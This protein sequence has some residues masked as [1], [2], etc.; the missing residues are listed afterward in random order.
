MSSIAESESMYLDERGPFPLVRPASA[1]ELCELVRGVAATDEAIFPKGGGTMLDY[2]LPPNKSG[3]VCDL[4]RL[5][6]VVDYPADDMTVT[7]EAGMTLAELQRVLGQ[8]RQWLP[9]DAPLPERTTIGGALATN[10]P[11]PRR[12][13]YGTWRDY[14]LGM[15]VVNDQGELTRSGGR[16][17]KNVAGYDLHKLHIGALGTLGVIVEV[18]FKVRPLP[19]SRALL[20]WRCTEDALLRIL[21][22]VQATQTRPV[23]ITVLNDRAAQFA[24]ALRSWAQPG[25]Y[26]V[27]IGFEGKRSTVAWQLTQLRQELSQVEQCESLGEWGDEASQDIWQWLADF[28]LLASAKVSFRASV[29]PSQTPYLLKATKH[30]GQLAVIAHAGSG[31][32]YGHWLAVEESDLQQYLDALRSIA[33]AISRVDAEAAPAPGRVL[34][35]RCPRAWKTPQLLW[36]EPADNLF[37]HRKI[38]E[39]FDPHGRFNP[40]RFP[41]GW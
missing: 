2:G 30:L 4:R 7:L 23:T 29:L 14:V 17:V 6:R 3:R 8:S 32:V 24:D 18:T 25:D 11:G 36:G 37:L 34:V 9:I 16:V 41:A 20:C 35:L 15:T 40:G 5:N 1:T 26:L 31:T 38:K 13:G 33:A 39:T 28:P 27:L 21:D 19:E 10:L 22:N 12:Y